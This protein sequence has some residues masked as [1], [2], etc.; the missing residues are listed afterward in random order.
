MS[1][2]ERTRVVVVGN[3]MVGHRFIETLI[4]R[5]ATTRLDVTVFGEERYPAYDRVNLSGFFDGKS[6][7]DLSLV[8]PGQYQDAGVEFRPDETVVAIDRAA[9]TVATSSG[10]TMS[11]D[12]LILATGSY[13]FVPPIPGADAP[14]CFVYRTIDDLEAIR[15]WSS[16]RARTGVVIGGGLLGLEAANALRNLGLDVN[17]VEFAPRLMALQVDEAGG[18]ILRR[19]IE[20]L[21]VGVHTSQADHGDRDAHRP[22][23]PARRRAAAVR[24]R[25]LAA[26]RHRR[27]L[28]RHP[29]RATSSRAPPRSRSAS[30]AASSSISAVAP[31]TPTSWPSASAPATTARP[32][33]WSR[34]ATTWPR[35]RLPSCWAATR[36]SPAS[37]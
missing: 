33:V 29:R 10:A 16:A 2:S 17:V 34:P 21:G 3:G 18:T 30:A 6:L 20:G 9:K 25:Q 31:P 1:A 19:R 27:L 8:K 36:C 22:R 4:T 35:S 13:P 23:R 12:K 7:A 28:G 37:T 24:G 14:G 11:Y 15:A 26:H 5:D 32:T